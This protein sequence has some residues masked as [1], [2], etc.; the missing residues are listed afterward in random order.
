MEVGTKGKGKTK[1]H[2]VWLIVLWLIVLWLIVYNRAL[3]KLAGCAAIQSL[4]RLPMICYS[5]GY[6]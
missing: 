6:S 2:F 1:H 4:L 3:L 5:V